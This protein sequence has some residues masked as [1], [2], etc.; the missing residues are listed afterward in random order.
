LH[1]AY[2]LTLGSTPVAPA[3]ALL[4]PRINPALQG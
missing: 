2:W 1:N 3:L 4:M